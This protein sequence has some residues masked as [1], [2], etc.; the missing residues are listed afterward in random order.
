MEIADVLDPM[1]SQGIHSALS[2]LRKQC[3]LPRFDPRGFMRVKINTVLCKRTLS[4]V[5]LVLEDS[6]N[7]S[8]TPFVDVSL[9]LVSI[10]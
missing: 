9:Q 6:S 3:L 2:V 1:S 7:R 8:F 5:R 10:I 4:P